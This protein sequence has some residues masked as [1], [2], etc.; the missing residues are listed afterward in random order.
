MRFPEVFQEWGEGGGLS[1]TME[2]RCT[3]GFERL[4]EWLDKF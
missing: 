1:L 4:V 3:L 2:K